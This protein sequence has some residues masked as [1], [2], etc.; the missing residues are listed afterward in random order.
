MYISWKWKELPVKFFWMRLWD[1]T[2]CNE[3]R[4]KLARFPLV[5][6]PHNIL[7]VITVCSHPSWFTGVESTYQCPKASI[8]HQNPDFPIRVL[9]QTNNVLHT[10]CTSCDGSLDP[11]FCS[12]V[13]SILKGAIGVPHDLCLPR[14]GQNAGSCVLNA[15]VKGYFPCGIWNKD[16]EISLYNLFV[17]ICRI[18]I[19]Q[20]RVFHFN[21]L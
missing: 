1:A 2:K 3:I 10:S 14:Y 12:T 11:P 20:R 9:S 15:E 16:T 19:L 21:L 7:T 5:L 17:F 6:Y 13:L 18:Y 8:H 4:G